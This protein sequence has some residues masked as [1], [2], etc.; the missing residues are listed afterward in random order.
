MAV[1]RTGQ[2]SFVEA[3]LPEGAG[4]PSRLGR[5]LGLVK[6]FRFAKLF[7]GLREPGT[8]ASGLCAACPVQ[9]AASAVAVRVVRCGARRGLERPAVVP[10]L[11]RFELTDAVADHTAL[12]RFR[13][14]LI[15]EGLLERLF[16]ELDRQL[17]QA[18]LALKR[19]TMPD[20]TLIEIA[21]STRPPRGGT[22]PMRASP[23]AAATGVRPSAQRPI[24][25]WARARA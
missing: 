22:I 24:S 23:S 2:M 21:A 3:L 14:R 8:G 11:R 16:A 25:G 7:G 19:G 20:A 13:L 10:A 4:R 18:G 5:L 1:K 15:D 9:G 6:W 12:C 17:D